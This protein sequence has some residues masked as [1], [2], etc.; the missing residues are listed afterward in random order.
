M[1]PECQ[2]L[3]RLVK[4]ASVELVDWI[5]VGEKQGHQGCRHGLLL[6]Q[7]AP[8]PLWEEFATVRGSAGD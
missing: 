1:L 2:P 6:D 4:E 5:N 8:E 3:F 7:H